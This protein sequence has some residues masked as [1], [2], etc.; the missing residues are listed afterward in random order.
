[1]GAHHSSQSA[2][3]VHLLLVVPS[4]G[5]KVLKSKF[6]KDA[7][8]SGLSIRQFFVQTVV[9]LLSDAPEKCGEL[10]RVAV[11]THADSTTEIEVD[12]L[13]DEANVYVQ[14]GLKKVIFYVEQAAV[15]SAARTQHEFVAQFARQTNVEVPC[16]MHA[17]RPALTK[18]HAQL[19]QKLLDEK[20]GFKGAADLKIGGEWLLDLV[21]ALYRLSPYHDKLRARSCPVPKRFA[22][23]S[24]AH[25]YKKKGKA[26][27]V[28]KQE[29]L[30]REISCLQRLA[31][32][33]HLDGDEWANWRDV[34]GKSRRT[35][36]EV[37]QDLR[38]AAGLPPLEPPTGIPLGSLVPPTRPLVT[39][40]WRA[41]S[42]SSGRV[43]AFR[44]RIL[45]SS[46]P[47]RDFHTQRG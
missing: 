32:Y 1:M 9:P 18:L 47:L 30:E 8:T 12:D 6:L 38:R 7:R 13:S 40:N 16:W 2:G 31:L 5:N 28:L 41:A 22:F 26:A 24:G 44:G 17:G 29:F 36:F 19:R 34:G 4:K 43:D 45:S 35:K 39:D 46:K 27:P 37:L 20:L 23:S 15:A 11:V 21:T 3:P 42:L 33:P 25:D 14:M 10:L